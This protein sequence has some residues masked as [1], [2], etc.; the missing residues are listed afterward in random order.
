HGRAKVG[1][2]FGRR[3]GRDRIRA[4]ANALISGGV[5]LEILNANAQRG[6]VGSRRELA[7]IGAKLVKQVFGRIRD[8]WRNWPLSVFPVRDST[9]NNELGRPVRGPVIPVHLRDLRLKKTPSD[10]AEGVY[11]IQS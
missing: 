3:V 2:D 11:S 9:S 8:N 1:R 6:A 4:R 5:H 7:R 10:C